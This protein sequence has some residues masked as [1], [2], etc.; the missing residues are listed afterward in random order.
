MSSSKHILFLCSW[1]PN[2]VQ[3][4][5]GNFIQK[6]AEAASLTHKISVVN[7]QP[8]ARVNKIELHFSKKDNLQTIIVYVPIKSNPLFKY[9]TYKKA[10]K[11]ATKKSAEEF[12]KIEILHLNHLFPL[13]YLVQKT[14]LPLVISEHYSGF[15]LGNKLDDKQV[16]LAKKLFKK[17]TKIIAVS[18]FLKT[19]LFKYTDN[20]NKLEVIGNVVDTNIFKPTIK[21]P[22]EKTHFLHISNGDEAS[23]NISGILKAIKQLTEITKNF[24]LTLVCDG[25]MKSMNEKARELGVYN[26]FVFF[27]EEQKTE[28]V[29][30]L[31][32]QADA[33]VMFSN[34]ETFGIVCAEALAC[35]TPV[36]AT[37]IPATQELINENNGILIEAENIEMLTGA[38][39]SYI[40]I[41]L[42]LEAEFEHSI[43]KEKFS[44]EVISEKLNQIYL[45]CNG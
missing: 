16:K 5:N 29:A 45:N 36:I 24:K 13:G 19:N 44:K 3:P 27:K 39:L 20:G 4:T 6:Q 30:E 25:D 2:R 38:L 28:E 23:K 7:I 8:D 26:N 12:G 43:I 18:D 9:L 37:N 35:G 34:Y 10:F 1:Y 42:K 15:V 21:I 32:Q 31:I 11:L 14:K 33:L 22:E 40:E 17:A 41:P